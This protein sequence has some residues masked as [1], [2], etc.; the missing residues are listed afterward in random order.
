MV[1]VLIVFFISLLICCAIAYMLGLFWFSDIRN[2]RFHTFFLLGIEVFVWTLLN[3]IT[4]VCDVTYFPIIYTI[5]MIMVCIVPFGATWFVLD[6]TN[7]PLKNNRL[8]RAIIVLIPTL[9]ILCMVTNPLHHLY[10]LDYNYTVPT[11]AILFWIHLVVDFSF[12]VTAFVFLIRFIVKGARRYPILV[13]P[14]IGMMIPYVLNLLY[15]FGAVPFPHDTTPIGFFFSLML[16]VFASYKLRL[17]NIKTALF[18]STMDSIND[19]IILFNERQKIMDVNQRALDTFPELEHML[20]RKDLDAFI[21]YLRTV[22]SDEEP[23]DLLE[24]IKAANQ[25]FQGEFSLALEGGDLRTYSIVWHTAYERKKISGHILMMA[26]VSSYKQ[27][28]QKFFELKEVAEAASKTKGEFLSRMSHEMRTPMNTI[29]GMT[30]VV[31]K[32]KTLNQKVKGSLQK[33]QGASAHLLGVINDVLDMS[34]IESGKFTLFES[35]ITLDTLIKNISAIADVTVLQKQQHFDVVIDQDLPSKLL[36]DSQRL[37]QVVTNLL[38]NAFK[39]SPLGG[40]I[41]LKIK[42]DKRQNK[43]IFLRFEV[44][45]NGIG[46]S[47]EQQMHLFRPFEQADGS[48]SRNFGGTGLGL[49]I[50]K[51][52]VELMGGEIWV[53]SEFGFGSCFIFTAWATEVSDSVTQQGNVTENSE[54][55]PDE[56]AGCHILLAEDIDINRNVI[57]A[58]LEDSGIIFDIAENGRIACEMYLAEPERYNIIFM[59]L[60]MPEMDGFASTIAIRSCGLPSAKTIPIIA[61]TANVFKE[62]IDLCLKAGMNDHIAKP[63]DTMRTKEIIRR[64]YSL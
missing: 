5:R 18:A 45:D 15:S 14:G 11:R 51:N 40:D 34:K 31:L 23:A 53:E 38:S 8:V 39:F 12:V 61:M 27:Q 46:I 6:F 30:E 7:S 50:S 49:A 59:D 20:G 19:I 54:G 29:I 21:T 58:L 43:R 24:Q 3:A 17:F 52:I 48:I 44:Q 32:D 36:V 22:I 41:T 10:F 63:I 37:T 4:M 2:R 60:Q 26:D 35:E 42:L 62:D 33:I 64:Y 28:N 47:E 57:L 55:Y 9:D 1:S 56:F 16:F 13:L 25:Q